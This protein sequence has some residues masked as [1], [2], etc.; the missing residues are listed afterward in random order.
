MAHV[1]PVYKFG[2]VQIHFGLLF[3]SMMQLVPALLHCV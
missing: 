3:E 2:H 1:L